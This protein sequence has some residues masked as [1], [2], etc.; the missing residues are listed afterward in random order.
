MGGDKVK[1]KTKRKKEKLERK[2]YRMRVGE[3]VRECL[4][5]TTTVAATA[6][7]ATSNALQYFVDLSENY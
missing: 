5:T 2:L 6:V 3:D 4:G 7:I 1:K